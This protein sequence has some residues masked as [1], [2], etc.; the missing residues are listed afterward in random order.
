MGGNITPASGLHLR[1][2]KRPFTL[3]QDS[4]NR[5]ETNWSSRQNQASFRSETK[6]DCCASA[7]NETLLVAPGRSFMVHGMEPTNRCGHMPWSR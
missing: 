5:R 6:L 4:L 3:L 1:R 2:K 7:D